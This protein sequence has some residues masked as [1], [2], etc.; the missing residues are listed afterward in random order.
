MIE[1]SSGTIFSDYLAELV[2]EH[3]GTL[4]EEVIDRYYADKIDKE[5]EYEEILQYIANQLIGEEFDNND[6]EEKLMS[7]LRKLVR[8]KSIG[9]LVIS[10]LISKYI[11]E[12]DTDTYSDLIDEDEDYMDT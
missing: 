2:D 6:L 10:Y 8:R 3:L 1:L 5:F 9:K 7:I 12:R 4:I 11:E